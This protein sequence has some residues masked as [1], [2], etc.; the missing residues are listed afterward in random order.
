MENKGK[1]FLSKE[2]SN[3]ENLST[4]IKKI[5]ICDKHNKPLTFYNI[6]N[7]WK[8]P[9]CID[10][11]LDK[12][13][14]EEESS[15]GRSTPSLMNHYIPCENLKNEFNSAITTFQTTQSK[16]K[17]NMIKY[18]NYF[19][20]LQETFMKFMNK[21]INEYFQKIFTKMK[22]M[23]KSSPLN[24]YSV[25]SPQA[26]LSFITSNEVSLKEL[27][28]KKIKIFDTICQLQNKLL[29]SNCKLTESINI[30]LDKFF[31][32]ISPK[33]KFEDLQKD[34]QN[35]KIIFIPQKIENAKGLGKISNKIDSSSNFEL[36]NALYLKNNLPEK[37]GCEKIKDR[38]VE[39]KKEEEKK[40]KSNS[41]SS[42]SIDKSFNSESNE[43]KKEEGNKK[44][45]EN[46]SSKCLKTR[47]HEKRQPYKDSLNGI[48]FYH[49]PSQ[50]FNRRKKSEYREYNDFIFGKCNKC[51]K[52]CQ[53]VANCERENVFCKECN[54]SYIEEKE[55]LF[56]Q[57]SGSD[58][59]H[60][61][62]RCNECN[63]IFQYPL[64]KKSERNKCF[65]CFKKWNSSNKH[66]NN[67]YNHNDNHKFPSNNPKTQ[68]FPNTKSPKKLF[69]RNNGNKPH[70]P[71]Y[72]KNKPYHYS[73]KLHNKR[74]DNK[75]K[76]RDG[77]NKN[78][79]GMKFHKKKFVNESEERKFKKDIFEVNFI[80]DE[81][82]KDNYMKS[83]Y[84][85]KKIKREGSYDNFFSKPLNE[86]DEEKF[87][88]KRRIETNNSEKSS[89][90]EKDF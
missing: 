15:K 80:E 20:L 51:G 61:S 46:F 32:N 11:L 71:D 6:S 56:K 18:E 1:N 29:S 40:S 27:Q 38:Y 76:R 52:E 41:N 78:R 14:R 10:C 2:I 64:E 13:K 88:E 87:G 49:D 62:K 83:K 54:I 77:T 33:K 3:P 9:L 84:G 30:L 63:S 45:L 60:V 28:E 7:P 79:G 22:E 85:K 58:K 89:S 23:Q 12:T 36:T 34:I 75:E 47:K 86:L 44:N 68:K 8:I 39:G 5:S 37:I 53:T 90:F 69:F 35:I 26:M 25:M 48:R 55:N 59:D 19:K 43:G 82:E 73:S 81:S 4:S 16:V 31:F 70:S 67:N 57:N 74:M 66:I 21:K 65:L 72:L 17:S 42:V 50:H 24:L